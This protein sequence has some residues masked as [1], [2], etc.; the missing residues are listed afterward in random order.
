MLEWKEN[1]AIYQNLKNES[2]L[3]A[4]SME[5]INR[6]WLPLVIY[7]NTDQQET[8]RLGCCVEWST[9][10]LVKREEDFRRSDLE[11]LDEAELYKV[12]VSLSTSYLLL[13]PLKHRYVC[14]EVQL[15]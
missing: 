1:R 4:L 8:T 15:L 11:D 12:P 2:Y 5:E 10:V 6:L 9:Y 7:T 13:M 14:N 3:N